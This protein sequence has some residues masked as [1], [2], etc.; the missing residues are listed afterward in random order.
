MELLS[1][2]IDE[3]SDHVDEPG[4]N[5]LPPFE[6]RLTAGNR[7]KAREEMEALVL[8]EPIERSLEGDRYTWSEAEGEKLLKALR[9][10]SVR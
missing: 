1:S 5:D 7:K 10:Q 2:Y 3:G 9:H 4:E 8:K 6:W